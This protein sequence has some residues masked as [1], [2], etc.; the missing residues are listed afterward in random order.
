[1][2][3]ISYGNILPFHSENIADHPLRDILPIASG[4]KAI[5]QR[6]RFLSMD[7]INDR[8]AVV[9]QGLKEI[10]VI[11]ISVRIL[12]VIIYP[13]PMNQPERFFPSLIILI[14]RIIKVIMKDR[15]D[16]NGVRSHFLNPGKPPQIR[17]LINCVVRSPF[18][19]N[20][21]SHIHSADLKRHNLTILFH[22]NRVRICCHK[23]CHRFIRMKINIDT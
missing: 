1:M 5:P 7:D 2:I 13:Y 14:E 22:I 17:L 16:P 18:S 20:S 4:T 10:I 23:S 15:V 9:Q 21:N 6:Q 8:P 12:D 11:S 3:C 19:R